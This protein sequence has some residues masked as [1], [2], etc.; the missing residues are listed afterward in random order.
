MPG[1]RF[2]W[3]AEVSLI[4]VTRRTLAQ[5]VR[6]EGLGLHSGIPVEVILSPGSEGVRFFFRDEC[7]I[8]TPDAVTDTTRSTSLR[9]VRTVEHLMSALSGLGITDV[10]V[11][12]SAAELPA[13]DGSAGP[14]CAA[15][16]SGGAVECGLRH[17]AFPDDGVAFDDGGVSIKIALGTGRWQYRYESTDLWPFERLVKVDLRATDYRQSVARAR[18]FLRQKDLAS[19]DG[20]GLA[21]GI[22][23]SGALIV[24]SEG[25]ATE[26]RLK[27]E[28]VVHKILDLIGDLYLTGIPA[29]FLDVQA[30]RSGHRANV[31]AASELAGIL[32]A[33]SLHGCG[34]EG[35][36]C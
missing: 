9:G 5:Q 30:R 15:L 18:T 31:A 28:L 36:G 16:D 12:L 10:D 35:L 8:A 21:R 13:M 25:Y 2:N 27:D 33:T 20:R 14:F 24:G 3:G 11:H 1:Q 23:R 7:V 32:Q 34:S 6:L 17:F 29:R 22:D 4:A 19:L 26:A